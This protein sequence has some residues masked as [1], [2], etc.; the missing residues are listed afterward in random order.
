[1]RFVSV[2]YIVGKIT[3]ARYFFISVFY[4]S[5]RWGWLVVATWMWT[6]SLSRDMGLLLLRFL[7]CGV[8]VLVEARLV[9]CRLWHLMGVVL[10]AFSSL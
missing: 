6:S 9:C 1:M 5:A 4:I 8:G 3:I 2:A 7:L 10:C